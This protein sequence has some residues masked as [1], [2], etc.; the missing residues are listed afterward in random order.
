[1]TN[2][3][4]SFKPNPYYLRK[5]RTFHEVHCRALNCS[6]SR[7][8]FELLADRYK[9][10]A[11]M[12]TLRERQVRR[13]LLK[14][15]EDYFEEMSK[16]YTI[17]GDVL[18][19]CIGS[20]GAAKVTSSASQYG[21]VFFDLID[22]NA[23]AKISPEEFRLFH[24]VFRLSDKTADAAFKALDKNDKGYVDYDEFIDAM[25]EFF[26]PDGEVET[27][28]SILFGPLVN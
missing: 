11:N 12:Q 28:E 14:I 4:V 15:W 13:K 23:D 3:K 26:V 24:K 16:T 2:E 27:P 19:E 7:A 5:M 1:M 10:V 8:A 9:D 20:K 17:T 25:V 18:A 21:D 22:L 6:F